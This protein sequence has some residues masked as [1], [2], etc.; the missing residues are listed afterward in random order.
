MKLKSHY[1]HEC[2]SA[3]SKIDSKIKYIN[4]T[5]FNFHTKKILSTSDLESSSRLNYSGCKQRNWKIFKNKKQQ[6]RA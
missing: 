1:G 5:N 2:G 3:S 4:K 6:D